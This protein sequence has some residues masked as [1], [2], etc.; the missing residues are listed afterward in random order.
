VPPRWLIPGLLALAGL[1]A[2]GFG[3]IQGWLVENR[4]GLA[5]ERKRQLNIL[6]LTLV[7]ALL[8]AESWSAPL[9]LAPVD[10][11]ASLNPAYAWLESQEKDFAL[12]ELPLHSAPAPEFP[13]VKRLY[14]STLGWWPL[15]NGYSG[16][17][18][19]RQPP[20]AQSLTAFPGP[21]ALAALQALTQESGWTKT[22]LLALVHPGEAP[23]QRSQWEEQDRWQA[24]R[25]PA[26]L[27]LGQ[28]EGDYLYRVMP[29]AERRF[30]EAPLAI[31]RQGEQEIRLLAAVPMLEE[32]VGLP[33][34]LFLYWQTATPPGADYTVF[35][36][37]R[38]A[39]GF[40]RSQADGPPVSG[41]YPTSQWQPGEVIQDIHPLPPGEDFGQIDH[42][43]VGLYEPAT[44][45]RLPAF[46]PEGIALKDEAVVVPLR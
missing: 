1:A 22:R 6:L 43:V 40:V 21:P 32:R 4:I 8:L 10:N 29:P 13:E 34:A 45:E 26:L 42:L 16:Y 39:D 17:T 14:A 15:V 44:G 9:P 35:V 3:V 7:A 12:V 27:P 11:R 41:H 38:A 19:P 24:E 23:F 37:L 20:L 2:M 25:H 31:F 30:P 5:P 36:H 18:P 46:S 33:P 28:F